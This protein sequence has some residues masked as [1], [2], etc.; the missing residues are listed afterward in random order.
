HLAWLWH[1]RRD[2]LH[3]YGDV[4]HGYIV[5]PHA[6]QHRSQRPQPLGV[7]PEPFAVEGPV[8]SSPEIFGRRVHGRPT[9][10]GGEAH[11]QRWKAAVRSAFVDCVLPA[12]CRVQVECEFLLAPEQRGRNEPDLDNLIKTTIDALDDVLGLRSGTGQRVEADDVRV[13]RIA[14]SKRFAAAGEQS[15]ARIVVQEL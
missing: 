3:V 7:D 4:E 9:G 10:Y 2:T 1:H 5:A 8:A 15:G 13:N 11:E 12:D 6:P 14:A